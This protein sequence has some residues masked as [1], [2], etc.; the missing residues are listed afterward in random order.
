MAADRL[1]L[2]VFQLE[3]VWV[4]SECGI[5]LMS[6]RLQLI[7]A[8][9]RTCA[10]GQRQQEHVPQDMNPQCIVIIVV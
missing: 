5:P 10:T 8:F 7:R 9:C 4:P 2:R 3:F 1:V 6:R